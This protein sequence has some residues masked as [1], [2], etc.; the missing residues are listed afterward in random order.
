MEA[1][2]MSIHGRMDK[3]IVVYTYNGIIFIYKKEWSTDTDYNVAIPQK[4]YTRE[5]TPETKDHILY[6]CTNMKY[7]GQ[8]NPL[9]W[10]ADWWLLGAWG[11]RNGE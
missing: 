8:V 5:K 2:Q 10:K 11:E 3:I 7:P 9:K 6:N 4:Y 1:I